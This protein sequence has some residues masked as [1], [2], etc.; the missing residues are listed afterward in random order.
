MLRIAFLHP[1]LGLGGAERLVV[2][3]A[4]GLARLGHDVTMFTSHYNPERCFSETRDGSFPVVVHGDWLPRHIAHRLHI[5][6]ATARNVWLAL[7]V[8]ARKDKFDVIICDQVSASVP[9]LRALAPSSKVL[10]YCHFPD[11][12]LAIPGSFIKR[13]YRVPFNALEECTTAMAHEIVV[14]SAFTRGVFCKTFKAIAGWLGVTPGVLHPCIDLGP[15]NAFP[16]EPQPSTPGRIVFLSIN[17]YER[18]KAVH[19]ALRAL[20]CL[21]GLLSPTQF[22]N[23]E[24]VIA[25][26]YDPRVLENVEHYE[27]LVSIAQELE[28][29]PKETPSQ[30]DASSGSTSGLRQRGAAGSASATSGTTV[31]STGRS[32]VRFIRSFTDKEKQ[33]LL[34]ECSAVLYTPSFEH[35]GIVPLE[36]MAAKRPVIA[37]NNGGPLE[38][39]V[40]EETG[41]L[42][43]PT[44]EAFAAAM[45]RFV[46]DPNLAGRM[47]AKGRQRVRDHFSR[48]AFARSLEAT[49]SDMVRKPKVGT[50]GPTL[51]LL[52]FFLV[53]LVVP[54][55]V[56]VLGL[57]WALA[58]VGH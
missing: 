1:D 10:F 40:H 6:F 9:V 36:T 43:E 18:K 30:A 25:G 32:Q 11:Q 49:C 17:R 46:K 12:L 41:F 14:N 31:A 29:F 34:R 28:L 44:P 58:A 55:V 15:E 48:D 27:E 26:G 22:A 45:A 54:A 4:A 39:V 47:G 2:D 19:L 23:V 38:T 53:F 52:A 57:R 20:G 16:A 24:V 3:A 50:W 37:V 13:V 42:C 51:L 21:R 56:G 5:V 35:F 8:A 7:A 33:D